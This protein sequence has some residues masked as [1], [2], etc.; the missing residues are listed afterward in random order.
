MTIF[1]T[2]QC[3]PGLFL[4]IQIDYEGGRLSV[5]CFTADLVILVSWQLVKSKGV[6]RFGPS[7]CRLRHIIVSRG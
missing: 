2:H 7:L 3:F 4:T 5:T 1:V 6:A